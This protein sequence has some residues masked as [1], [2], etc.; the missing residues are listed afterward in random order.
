MKYYDDKD[1]VRGL[2]EISEC[3]FPHQPLDIRLVRR[4]IQECGL[5][6]YRHKL[7]WIARVGDLRAWRD[8]FFFE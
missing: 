3:L 7:G 2:L 8:S 5:P 1:L 4:Y 6:A